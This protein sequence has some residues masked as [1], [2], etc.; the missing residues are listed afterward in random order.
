MQE[1]RTLKTYTKSERNIYLLSMLGQNMIY[2]VVGAAFAYYLQFTIL[3]PALIVSGILTAAKVWDAINDFIM[4]NLVDRTRTKWGKCRPY[5]IFMPIPIMV[6]TLL[7]FVNF[8]FYDMNGSPMNILIVAWA[9]FTYILFDV[10]YTMADIPLWSVTALMTESD[11]DRNKLLS[12]AKIFGGIGAGITLLAIQPTALWLGDLLSKPLG[13]AAEGERWGFFISAV[14]FTSVGAALFQLCGFKIRERVEVSEKKYTFKDNIKIIMGNKP[15]KQI[16]LSGI[17]G[18]PKMLIGLSAMPLVTYY[19]ATKNAGLAIL[20][21]AMLG[22][23]VLIGQFAGMAATPA[24]LKRFTKKNLYNYSNLISVLPF[25]SIFILYLVTPRGAIASSPALIGILFVIFV[26]CGLAGGVGTVLQSTMIAD[27][28]DYEEHKNGVRPDGVFFAGQTFLAKL[29][30]GL[31]TL[32]SGAAYAA[33]GFSDKAIEGLNNYIANMTPDSLLPRE[34]PEYDSY[35]MILFFLVSIPPAIG[36]IITVIPTWKY[37][38]DDNVHKKIL[39]ELNIR[40]GELEKSNEE[41]DKLNI[42]SV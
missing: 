27:C 15:F 29:T 10:V 20:Y 36:S 2:N 16:M 40:R 8:G 7:C 39:A 37:S 41:L 4:G 33:V 38:L 28:I 5:L 30:T 12:L 42:E 17:L 26:I 32:I 31:A 21:L 24:L 35:M 6:I 14:I 18:T 11:K 34:M 19:F 25:A 22:G 3:I 13:S 1:K 23:G 9:A